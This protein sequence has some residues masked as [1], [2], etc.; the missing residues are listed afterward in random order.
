MMLYVNTST[1]LLKIKR[2]AIPSAVKDDGE[3]ELSY[4]AGIKSI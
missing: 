3:V 2:L 1:T 4:A